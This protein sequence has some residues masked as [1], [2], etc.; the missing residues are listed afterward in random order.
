MIRKM[1]S[2]FIA[3]AM[4]SLFLVLGIIMTVVNALNYSTII[5]DA[6]S[7]LAVLTEN[8]GKFPEKENGKNEKW[9]GNE[10]NETEPRNQNPDYDH[11]H[12]HKLSEE[13]PYESRFFWITVESG[14][15]VL[16]SNTKHIAAVNEETAVVMAMAVLEKGGDT[17]FFGNYRYV[18]AQRDGADQ[19][20]FLDCTR[21][22][23][24]FRTFLIASL[25]ISGVGLAAVFLLMLLLSHR[26]MRP[27]LE[28]YEKQKRFITDA[29]HEIKT[30][31][32][33]IDADTEVL[34]MEQGANEWLQD[35]RLQ[36]RKLRELT[37]QLIFLSRMEEEQADLSMLEFPLSDMVAEQVQSFQALARTQEKQLC[38]GIE[39]MLSYCGDP[40][41]LE[42]LVTILLDNALKYS[43][44]GS[45]IQVKLSRQSRA[46]V[47]SVTNTAPGLGREAL[48]D[49]FDRFYR[50]DQ[51]RSSRTGGFG[52]GLSVARAVAQAHKGRV[53]AA[54]D[55][56]RLTI[57]VILPC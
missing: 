40:Q 26:I 22:L 17:G 38:L 16:A 18:V 6:D 21:G 49:L 12:A 51:S 10:L 7:I 27:V 48:P 53:E 57:T 8:E 50:T 54:L 2:R 9:A 35:I 33:V 20:I 45:D 41:S 56:E 36:S 46:I 39:P 13:A 34:E 52:I 43:P 4:L 3:S 47:F 24:N 28:S 32:T 31:I 55:G 42:K 30:P 23:Q 11:H 15:M 19:V 25:S 44:A 37:D 29:G 1:R 5:R 14:G